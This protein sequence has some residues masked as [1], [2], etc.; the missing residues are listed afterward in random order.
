VA[1]PWDSSFFSLEALT[2]S[3][4]EEELVL[5]QALGGWLVEHQEGKRM[6]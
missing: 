2:G 3:R 6:R 5:G 1:A 4:A